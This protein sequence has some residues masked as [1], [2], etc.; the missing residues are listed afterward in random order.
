[1]RSRVRN[2]AWT[3]IYVPRWAFVIK[4]LLFVYWGFWAI[5]AGIPAF[6]M[7]APHGWSVIW[8]SLMVVAGAVSAASVTRAR[9]ERIERWS[10][11]VLCVLS[12]GYIGSINVLA[13]VSALPNYQALAAGISLVFVLPLARFL[14]LAAQAGKKKS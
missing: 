9:G 8:G 1:M 7:T 6:D 12:I 11:G 3:P 2:W 5:L 10:V 4:Y 14:Y 13:F